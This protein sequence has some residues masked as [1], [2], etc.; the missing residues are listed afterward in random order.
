MILTL[1]RS[2]LLITYFE[3][4]RTN[5]GTVELCLFGQ[6]KQIPVTMTTSEHLLSMNAC[7]DARKW[8]EKYSTWE[9][10]IGK[11]DR[12][13]WLLWVEG[14]LNILDDKERRLLAVQFVRTT[15]LADGRTVYDLLTDERSRN[16]LDVAERYANGIAT[17]DEL[18]AA[19]SAAWIAAR[20]AAWSAADAAESAAESAARSA[21]DAA[22]SAAW[23]AAR[24]AAWSA[25]SSAAWNAAASAADA[26]RSAADAAGIAAWSAADAAG[27]H[28]SKYIR[29]KYGKRIIAALNE[30]Y[31][32]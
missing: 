21:A 17:Q 11:C 4:K 7:T 1:L 32:I 31:P 28:Q 10:I 13:D 12:G 18:D 30:K 27:S 22:W 9:K 8:A 2:D 29:R 24:S 15:P 6:A 25:A 26:A 5:I 19:A 3:G 20:S 23:S 16:A 14:K